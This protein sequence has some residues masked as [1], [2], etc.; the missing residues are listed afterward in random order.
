[1]ERKTQAYSISD[2]KWKIRYVALTFA[3]MT[4]K[5]GTRSTLGGA[6]LRHPGELASCP[7]SRF[8]GG[9]TVFL[10]ITFKPSSME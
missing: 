3:L 2:R 6:V 9:M 5:F 1:M 7:G 10:K 8:V 4:I